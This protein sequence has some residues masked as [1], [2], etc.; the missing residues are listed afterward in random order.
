MEEHSALIEAIFEAVNALLWVLPEA[1]RPAPETVLAVPTVL[2]GV[3]AVWR[4]F[5]A[6][7]APRASNHPLVVTLDRALNVLA[8]NSRRLEVRA[9]VVKERLSAP[10]PAGDP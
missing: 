2:A 9:P 3:L 4:W 10:P 7:Y 1:Y 5:M 8:V 6:R